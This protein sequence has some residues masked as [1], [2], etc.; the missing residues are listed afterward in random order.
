MTEC[1]SWFLAIVFI[2]ARR[3]TVDNIDDINVTIRSRQFYMTNLRV[4][5]QSSPVAFIV[6]SNSSS[7]RASA[8]LIAVNEHRKFVLEIKYGIYPDVLLSR[9]SFISL[10]ASASSWRSKRVIGSKS[11]AEL[12]TDEHMAARFW[13]ISH[14]H[15]WHISLPQGEQNHDRENKAVLQISIERLFE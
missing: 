12:G 10:V 15:S 2:T 6:C 8:G 13:S 1:R 4:Y 14:L 11:C 7:P 9:I 5:W 3:F